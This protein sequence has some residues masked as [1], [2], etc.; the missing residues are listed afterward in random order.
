MASI[1]IQDACVLINL[2]ASGR[3]EDII[4]GCG[5]S[6][7]ISQAVAREAMVL[8][9]AETNEREKIDL[10]PLI[11]KGLLAVLAAESE[12]EKLRFIELTMNLDDGEAES[13]AIAE[14]RHFALATDDRKARNLIQRE[15]LNI[16]LWSTCALL[17]HW[18]GRSSVADNEMIIILTHILQRARYRPKA[19]HPHF[20]WWTSLM[21]G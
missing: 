12:A 19:G 4:N 6:F 15:G 10:Q 1:V 18:Q 3:F 13:V 9:Y 20:A 5:L 16:E 11:G 21:S 14:A 2:L 8:H 7:A 17:Q